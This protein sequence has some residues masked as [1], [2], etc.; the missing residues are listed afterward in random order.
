MNKRVKY[1][2]LDDKEWCKDPTRMVPLVYDISKSVNNVCTQV[3]MK[4]STYCESGNKKKFHRSFS[5][6]VSLNSESVQS[7]VLSPK[8]ATTKTQTFFQKGKTVPKIIVD[9]FCPDLKAY[10]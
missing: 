8:A 7:Y 9:D 2:N 1:P 10:D 3:L 5:K 4:K 6:V